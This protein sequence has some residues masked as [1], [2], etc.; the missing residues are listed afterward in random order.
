[1]TNKPASKSL[2][3]RLTPEERLRLED[4]AGSQ[5]L[6][7]Y[8]RTKLL[9]EKTVKRKIRGG[10]VVKDHEALGHVLGLLGTSEIAASLATLAKAAK[11]GS[12]PVTPET[13]KAL[14]AACS[15]I[16]AM[17]KALMR[18]LGFRL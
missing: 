13:E 2:S 10:H 1:M 3:V 9:G 8:V 5:P 16:Q 14:L 7:W 6:S 4:E 11:S 18:A 15:Y 17:H 12:L